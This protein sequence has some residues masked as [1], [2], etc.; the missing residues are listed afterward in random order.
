MSQ[1]TGPGLKG[2]TRSALDVRVVDRYIDRGKIKAA[3]YDAHLKGL[4]DDS[5]NAQ[6][7]QL[8]VHDDLAEGSGSEES[9]EPESSFNTELS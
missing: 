5:A 3:D 2:I 6:W 7:V 4:T 8:D 1:T 9:E